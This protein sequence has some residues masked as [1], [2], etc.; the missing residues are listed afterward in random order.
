MWHAAV[1][2]LVWGLVGLWW[3]AGVGK[4]LQPCCAERQR[5]TTVG[6]GCRSLPAVACG[7]PQGTLGFQGVLP[8]ESDCRHR[9]LPLKPPLPTFRPPHPLP[10]AAGGLRCLNCCLFLPHVAMRSMN[11]L[12]YLVWGLVGLWW[13]AEV[14][15]SCSPAARR[16]IG[17][18]KLAAVVVSCLQ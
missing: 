12:F 9:V 3:L 2:Y 14:E 1:N 11:Y 5:W 18:Q 15:D 10:A 13:L 4:Q 7:E 6:S 8:H 17:G 16:G